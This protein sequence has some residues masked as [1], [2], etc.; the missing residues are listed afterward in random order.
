MKKQ[1]GVKIFAA[2]SE[3]PEE[4]AESI[5]GSFETWVDNQKID[6]SSIDKF[7]THTASYGNEYGHK[8]F[9]TLTVTYCID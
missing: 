9:L 4:A 3:N 8:Y 6:R 1:K 2:K 5:E 7:E